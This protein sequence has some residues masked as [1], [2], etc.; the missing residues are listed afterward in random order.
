MICKSG[1]PIQDGSKC[2]NM[3]RVN[4]STGQTTR[5]L[6]LDRA[7]MKKDKLLVYGA[8]TVELINNGKFCM[9]IKPQR[10][11]QRD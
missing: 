7:K 6:M 4:S 8:T 2:S 9:L 5:F 10:L 3:R 1:A 11:K